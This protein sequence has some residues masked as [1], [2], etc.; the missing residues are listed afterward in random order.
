MTNT[1]DPLAE[2][3]RSA[4]VEAG[5]SQR[6]VSE[7]L[8]YRTPQFV[9]NW[10]RG[11][12]SPPGRMLRKIAEIYEVQ[13]E[14]LYEHLIDQAVRKL[15]EGLHQEVFGTTLKRRRQRVG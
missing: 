14:V 11:V 2:F 6:E 7:K 1:K 15:E 10:E 13:A 3:L 4:R 12:S 8:G 9:S 5:L